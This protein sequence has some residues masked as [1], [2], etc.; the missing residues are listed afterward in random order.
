[1]HSHGKIVGVWVD[2]TVP[3]SVYEENVSFYQKLYDLGVDMLTTDFPIEAN[4]ALTEYHS[5]L[6]GKK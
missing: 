4:K 5:K 2:T 6:S 1:M 3:S